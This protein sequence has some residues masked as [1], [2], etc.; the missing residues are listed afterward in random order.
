MLAVL[1]LRQKGKTTVSKL[2]NGVFRYMLE[3]HFPKVLFWKYSELYAPIND[4]QDRHFPKIDKLDYENY[5]VAI[6]EITWNCEW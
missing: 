5:L 4:Q 6:N 2:P 1:K 3:Y